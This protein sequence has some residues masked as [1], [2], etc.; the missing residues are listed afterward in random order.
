MKNPTTYDDNSERVARASV[1]AA[2]YPICKLR[3]EEFSGQEK[4]GERQTSHRPELLVAAPGYFSAGGAAGL[5]L[6]L[7][8]LGAGAFRDCG[9][10]WVSSTT[11][12]S[13]SCPPH[14]LPSGTK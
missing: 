13:S 6:A 11:V 12:P 4:A 14:M 5:S 8:F 1:K 10:T 7:C 3:G 9:C 2:A